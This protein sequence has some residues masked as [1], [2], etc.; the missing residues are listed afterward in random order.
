[1][2]HATFALAV[3]DD[4]DVLGRLYTALSLYEGGLIVKWW[5]RRSS[6][7][8]G[9]SWGLSGAHLSIAPL[10]DDQVGWE[11]RS[12][13]ATQIRAFRRPEGAQRLPERRVGCG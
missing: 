12:G 9:L 4:P 8:A 2:D 3:P 11:S 6:W 1:M 13:G 7:A 10:W 5:L